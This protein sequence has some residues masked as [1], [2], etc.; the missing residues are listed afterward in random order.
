MYAIRSYY[1]TKKNKSTS[2][3]IVDGIDNCL[4]KFSQCCNPL[5][6][7]DIIGFITRGHGVSIHKKDCVNYTSRRKTPE[8]ESRWIAVHW[9]KD[10]QTNYNA[11][12]DIVANDRNGL[13][14]D[15]S[16]TLAG[17]RI[18][19]H[20]VFARELK[21]GNANVVITISIA[22]TEQLNG[23]INKLRKIDGVI[24]IDRGGK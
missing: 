12:L 23:V 7:D 2:G 24:S 5:P 22:G 3:I 15:I 8:D 18:P 19:I 16:T 14:A 4:I 11:T 10:N 20:E 6:G 9:A 13:L 17:I 1:V 21:N